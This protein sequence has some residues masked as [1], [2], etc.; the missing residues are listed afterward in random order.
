MK[1][2][3]SRAEFLGRF[4]AVQKNVHWAWAAV[5]EDQRICYFSAWT[6]FHHTDENGDKYYTIQQPHWGQ[7]SVQNT[8]GRKDQDE[9]F[10]LVF[11]QGYLPRIYFVEV[12]DK[13]QKPRQIKRTLTSFV[14]DVRLVETPEEIRAYLTKRIE[15]K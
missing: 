6:D 13:T 1:N 2:N 4:G 11:E 14:C 12:V 10:R 7:N 9:K 15:L 8:F 3:M 5:N